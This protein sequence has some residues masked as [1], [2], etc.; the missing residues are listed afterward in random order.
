MKIWTLEL[1]PELFAYTVYRAVVMLISG[2]P[3]IVPFSVLIEIPG[4]KVG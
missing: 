2:L 3:D 4:G 1:P